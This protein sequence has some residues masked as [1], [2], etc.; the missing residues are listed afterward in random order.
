MTDIQLLVLTIAIVWPLSL[1]IY[2]LNRIRLEL[3]RHGKKPE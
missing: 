2:C 1:L 3:E